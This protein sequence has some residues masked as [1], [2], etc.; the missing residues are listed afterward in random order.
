MPVGEEWEWGAGGGRE[1][2]A[3]A[4]A[5]GAGAAPE[6]LGLGAVFA[7]GTGVPSS[8][9]SSFESSVTRAR[10]FASFLS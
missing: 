2:D 10:K 6:E 7:G 9:E 3:S 1:D 8:P 4:R 5:G